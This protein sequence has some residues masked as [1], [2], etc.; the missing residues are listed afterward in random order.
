T[1][2][3]CFSEGMLV[4]SPKNNELTFSIKEEL[5]TFKNSFYNKLSDYEKSKFLYGSDFFLA[6]FFGPTM[7]QYYADFKEAFGD[8][9]DIIASVNPKRFLND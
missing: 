5:G 6:Q 4:H 3:S 9:F 8:D 2:L 7:E 1:D